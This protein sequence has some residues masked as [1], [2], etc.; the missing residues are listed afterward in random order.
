MTVIKTINKTINSEKN[1]TLSTAK[2][3]SEKNNNYNY[4]EARQFY[5]L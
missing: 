4:R 3:K 1:K 2:I 5:Y